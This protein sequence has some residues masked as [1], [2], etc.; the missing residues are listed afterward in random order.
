MVV[1]R[2]SNMRCGGC[3]KSVTKAVRGVDPALDVR[4]DLERREITVE[5]AADADVLA[6]ALHG[7]G[8]EGER[9]GA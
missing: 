8:F 2:V 9:T 1:F 3:V 4:V 5:G 7:A 6:R